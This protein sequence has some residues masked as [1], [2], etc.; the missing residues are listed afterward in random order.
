MSNPLSLAVNTPETTS[1]STPQSPSVS[2][3]ETDLEATFAGLLQDEYAQL[4]PSPDGL[5]LV[6]D[7]LEN[8][9]WQIL[10]RELDETGN[11]LPEG[12]GTGTQISLFMAWQEPLVQSQSVLPENK[13]AALSQP[14]LFESVT[15]TTDL[16][17]KMLKA[18]TLIPAQQT[19]NMENLVKAFVISQ[20]EP[21]KADPL[22]VSV[23]TDVP[24][25]QSQTSPL[26][27]LTATQGR[28]DITAQPIAIPPT[29]PEWGNAMGERLQWMV[30]NNIQ[31]AEIRLDP[32]ELGSVDVK[33]VIH[34]DT[35][36][37]N[38]IT[39]HAQTRDAV[40]QAMPRLREMFGETG[41]SLGDVNVS[42]ESFKQQHAGNENQSDAQT[43]HA[44]VMDEGDSDSSHSDSVSSTGR[45]TAR[46]TGLLDTYV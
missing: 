15:D 20:A 26:G 38:F 42:Q 32:P 13:Q 11:S 46:G 21:S 34:K 37:V 12:E 7:P 30:N 8:S 45:I 36:Q 18:S 14:L 27:P 9:E 19:N 10:T 17:N 33:I 4:E 28:T 24:N 3:E 39:H 40:E 1:T 22:N 43:A 6:T 5:P 23:D 41:L 29:R 16:S 2:P 25:V 44:S 31:S 35:A